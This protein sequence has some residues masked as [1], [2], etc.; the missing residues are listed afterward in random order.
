MQDHV[1][2]IA[3][4]GVGIKPDGKALRQHQQTLFYPGPSVFIGTPAVRVLS[5]KEGAADTAG[6]AMEE[7]SGFRSNDVMAGISHVA[8]LRFDQ[9][10]R[11]PPMPHACVSEGLIHGWPRFP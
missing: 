3:H 10:G 2:V 8:M 6:D 9:S 4:D 7:A 11:N 1:H 5:A